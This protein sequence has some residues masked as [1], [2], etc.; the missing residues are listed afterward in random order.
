MKYLGKYTDDQLRDELKRRE[1]E[2][3]KNTPREI[4]YVE[5]TATIKSI[6]NKRDAIKLLPFNLWT[7]RIEDCSLALANKYAF[8]SYKLKQGIFRKDESPKVGDRVKLRYRRTKKMHE[9]FDLSKSKI[10]E[11]IKRKEE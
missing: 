9:V 7:Y 6:D 4:V 2:R 10:V 8:H 11:L 5:Y 3:R 1:R